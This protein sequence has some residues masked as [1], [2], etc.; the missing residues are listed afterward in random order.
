MAP[1]A[2]LG[3]AKKSSPC[4][5]VMIVGVTSG[6][7]FGALGSCQLTVSCS[8]WSP[9]ST[10]PESISTGMTSPAIWFSS[11]YWASEATIWWKSIRFWKSVGLGSGGRLRLDHLA[12]SRGSLRPCVL[13]SLLV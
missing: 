4:R 7:M 2:D 5:R 9:S 11:G 13:P 12:L 6:S 8:E 3:A 1:A 10:I